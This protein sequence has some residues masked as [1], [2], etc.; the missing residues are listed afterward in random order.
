MWSSW[1]GSPSIGCRQRSSWVDGVCWAGAGQVGV[2]A[3]WKHDAVPRNM[4]ILDGSAG[5]S[6]PGAF[7]TQLHAVVNM[8]SLLSCSGRRADLCL[9]DTLCGVPAFALCVAPLPS[10]QQRLS[11]ALQ[12]C[13]GSMS[14]VLHCSALFGD[15]S[16]GWH[17]LK[18]G[19]GLACAFRRRPCTRPKLVL[20]FPKTSR[21]PWQ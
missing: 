17:A 9:R 2:G 12:R 6:H 13:H 7:P 19:R 20:K 21:R 3:I 8:T 15:R 1:P 16:Q 4:L 11:F 5:F 18:L 14:S 10:I